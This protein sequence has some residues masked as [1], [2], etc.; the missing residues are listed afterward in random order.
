MK[1]A[2]IYKSYLGATREYAEWLSES[3]EADVFRYEQAKEGLLGKYDRLI[4]MSGTYAG[5]MPLTRFLTKNWD[6]I[7]NKKIIAIA[8]GGEPADGK[9]SVEAY[10]KIPKEIRDNIKY[11]KIQGKFF[12]FPTGGI[13]KENLNEIIEY[14]KK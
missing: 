3:V 4:V 12:I 8:V 14:I 1:T 5:T 11:Y 10:H 2:I 13:K 9:G 7:K 6:D